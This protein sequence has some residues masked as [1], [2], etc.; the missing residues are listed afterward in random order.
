LC[1]GE[2]ALLSAQVIRYAGPPAHDMKIGMNTSGNDD[3]QFSLNM[4]HWLSGLLN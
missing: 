1:L 3:R 2:A 4:F